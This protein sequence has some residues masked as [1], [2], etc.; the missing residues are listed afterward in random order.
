MKTGPHAIG[1]VE[2]RR[3]SEKS[4]IKP[5]HEPKKPLGSLPAAAYRRSLLRC[6]VDPCLVGLAP[7]AGDFDPGLLGQRADES[8]DRVLLPSGTPWNRVF[9]GEGNELGGPRFG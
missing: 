6:F 2:E 5:A 9:D 8:A 4:P 7:G 3:R 1:V